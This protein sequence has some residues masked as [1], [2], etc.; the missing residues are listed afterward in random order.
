MELVSS[1]HTT[2]EAEFYNVS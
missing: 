2:M 1:T